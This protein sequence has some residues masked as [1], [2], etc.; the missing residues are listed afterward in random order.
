MT[1]LRC[2]YLCSFCQEYLSTGIY[3]LFLC[4]YN[5]SEPSFPCSRAVYTSEWS[6]TASCII[7]DSTRSYH[8]FLLS[9]HHQPQH[10]PDS[11]NPPLIPH[12]LETPLESSLTDPSYLAASAVSSRGEDLPSL[13]IRLS[14]PAAFDH[15]GLA[16]TSTGSP[17]QNLVL[18]PPK[19][20]LARYPAFSHRAA[21]R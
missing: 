8:L 10:L 13:S 12:C 3:P 19:T 14:P 5:F 4:L 17:P 18:G 1:G 20:S 2:P 11:F 15:H 7:R 9:T 16:C 6:D 21:R